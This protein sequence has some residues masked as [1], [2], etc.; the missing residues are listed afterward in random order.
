MATA[1]EHT[2]RAAWL[3]ER[4][5]IIG[6]SES[7]TILGV[8]YS[9]A[10]V[11]DLWAKK[12]GRL[13]LDDGEENEFFEWGHAIQPVALRIF[14][15]RTGMQVSDPGEFTVA[16]HPSIPWLGATLDGIA[17]TPEGL[18]VVECKNVGAYNSRDWEADEPPLRVN[19]QI[20]HQIEVAGATHGYA[21][22]CVGGNKL[23]WRRVNRD[24]RFIAVMLERL[25]EFWRLVET[26]TPPEVDGSEATSRT[27]ARL[28]PDDTG[29][30]TLLPDE[31]DQWDAELVAVKAELKNLEERERLLKNRFAAAL[32]SA[33]L[34]QTPGGVTYTYKQQTRKEY[35][36]AAS[37]FRVLRRKA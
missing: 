27:L 11:L 10:S 18:A 35:V 23:V 7:P 19:V 8:G 26:D 36:C 30:M 15:K 16:R 9:G 1:S 31:S 5:S 6:A 4:R 22:A 17:D 21:V 32:E 2:A 14:S 29:A 3:A 28:Y 24:D 13:P 34:G 25:A 33:T 20:Q 12:T 37:T